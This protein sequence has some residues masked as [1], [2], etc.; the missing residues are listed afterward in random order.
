VFEPC[1]IEGDHP[2]VRQSELLLWKDNKMTPAHRRAKELLK[3]N[4][5]G[6]Y[7]FD[8]HGCDFE[9]GFR[10]SK[11]N[12]MVWTVVRTLYGKR[13]LEEAGPEFS[14]AVMYRGISQMPPDEDEPDKSWIEVLWDKVCRI[15]EQAVDEAEIQALSDEEKEQQVLA[16]WKMQL[17]KAG[18]SIQG[19]M[20]RASVDS[21][22][23]VMKRH[24][25]L[26]SPRGELF[27]LDQHGNYKIRGV[28]SAGL[29]GAIE[30]MGLGRLYGLKRF[31]DRLNEGELKRECGFPLDEI[32]GELGATTARL[33]GLDTDCS[34]LHIPTYY[35]QEFDPLFVSEVDRW[36]RAF[37]GD[38]Y[39]RL[40][41]W[42]GHAQNT[43][44]PICALSLTGSTGAGKTFL[45]ELM[46][47]MFG[48][49]MKNGAQIFGQWNFRL[50]DNPVI[51]LDEDLGELQGIRNID[52]RFREFVTGGNFTL[53][54]RNV[55]ERSFE[56]YPRVILAANDLEALRHIVASRDLADDSHYALAERLLHIE[57][58]EEARLTITRDETVNWIGGDRLALRHFA[59]L[60]ENRTKPSDWAGTGRFLVEGD[61]ESEVLQESR[62]CSP[63]IEAVQRALVKIVES[64]GN[65]AS[66]AEVKGDVVK[67]S[68]T[69]IAEMMNLQSHE[70][71]N[72]TKSPKAIGTALRK[73]SN[74]QGTRRPVRLWH[75]PIEIL[76]RY[77]IETGAPCDRLRKIYIEMNSPAALQA[78]ED[79]VR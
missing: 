69:R 1:I 25:I 32:V 53:S 59:W 5:Y 22:I 30:S 44:R 34:K 40:I 38:K 9:P 73:L 48:P 56:V 79:K 62:F 41:D 77:A 49:G 2:D 13:G 37:A 43:T 7:L 31:G 28:P 51:H 19:L 75:V 45:G 54:Q 35:R 20:A 10:D 27:L 17:S 6:A 71:Y 57:V 70:F 36:L 46:G 63:V 76:L 66:G 18:T 3:N 78:L 24:L 26:I 23:E 21:E 58:N 12:A 61:R 74:G 68:A 15:W 60:Y 50:R 16:G 65:M 4:S 64:S 14:F 67:A 42:I 39:E 11:I 8:G 55:D 33:S 47:A 29:H 72:I 52:A